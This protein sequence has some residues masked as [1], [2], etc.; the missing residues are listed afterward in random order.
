MKVN[1]P[2]GQEAE[3]PSMIIECCS[4]ERTYQAFYVSISQKCLKDVIQT[5]LSRVLNPS[6]VI[7]LGITADSNL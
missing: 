7:W 6:N 1:L 5:S 3:L 2:V 4:Q